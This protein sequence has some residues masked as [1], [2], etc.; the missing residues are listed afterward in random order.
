MPGPAEGYQAPRRERWLLAAKLAI[1]GGTPVLPSGAVKPWPHITDDDRRAVMAVLADGDLARQRGAQS[2]GLAK[3]FAQ[4][5]GVSHAIPCNSG[6]A[7]LHMAVAGV[8]V[9]P[10]DEVIC[11]AFTYWATAAAVLHHNAIP[12]FVDV[13][14]DTQCLDPAFLEERVS[15]RTRAV[16]PVHIHGMPA[17]MDPILAVARRHHLSVIEDCA[18]AHGARYRGRLT[19]TMGDAAG[20][21]LQMTKLLTAGSEGGI[22]VT[23]DEQIAQRAGL[24][25]YLGELVVPGRER[26]DQAYNAYGLGWMYRGDVF[27]QAFARS[28]L[29]RLD[30]LTAARVKNC[31]LL[32]ELLT[33]IPGVLPPASRADREATYFNY[34]VCLRPGELGLDVPLAEFRDKAMRA[35]R[36]EGVPIGLWQRMSVPAQAIFQAKVGYGKGCPW[37]CPHARPDVQYRPEDYPVTNAFVDSRL[38]LDGIWPP[39]DEQLM[40]DMAGAFGKVLSVPDEVIAIDVAA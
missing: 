8:G 4:Y 29:R 40:H 6:T 19:G 33:P 27:G 12:V 28:Q 18:Q 9:E 37:N 1:N 21:S 17:D 32:T 30:E 5:L 7:A 14:P 2:E 11:P 16:M 39:N 25:Q 15:D 22:F 10:G 20:F 24:L 23:D 13:E 3:E 34:V 36:A 38:Y 31:E 35:L 26:T